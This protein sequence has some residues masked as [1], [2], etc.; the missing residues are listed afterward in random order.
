MTDFISTSIA[1]SQ[2]DV[3]GYTV[4]MTVA[5][6]IAMAMNDLRDGDF[7]RG[8]ILLGTALKAQSTGK[9]QSTGPLP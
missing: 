1:T 4:S 3:Q 2:D 6:A 8:I 9:S 7:A 5:G